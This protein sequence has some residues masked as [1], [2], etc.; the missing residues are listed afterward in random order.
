[1]KLKTFLAS[2]MVLSFFWLSGVSFGAQQ[3]G[4]G[5][6]PKSTPEK[7]IGSLPVAYLPESRY[8]FSRV[9]DGTEVIHDFVIQNKGTGLL[10][11][12]KVKTG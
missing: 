11:I 4:D 9:V 3:E 8:E 2:M 5:G 1:M 10:K 6:N 12:E 7:E